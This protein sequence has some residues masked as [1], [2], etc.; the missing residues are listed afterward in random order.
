MWPHTKSSPTRRV[1]AWTSTVATGPRPRSRCASTTVPMAF[2]SGFA[3][4]SR[5]SDDSTI[6]LAA[7][8]ARDDSLGRKLLVDAVGV[9]SL[10]VHLV[11]G[12][13]D[14][15]LRGSRVLDRL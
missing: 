2:L 11:D 7:I 3:F 6:V 9:G 1:P 4:S 13:D 8:V 10:L 5:M 14:R 15:N 12:D